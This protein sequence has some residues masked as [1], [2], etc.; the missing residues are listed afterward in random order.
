MKKIR[1]LLT[2]DH[3]AFIAG[4]QFELEKEPDLEV[5][6]RAATGAEA[7]RLVRELRPDLLLLDMELPD[8]SGVEVA[9]RLQEAETPVLILPL[10]G[11]SDPEYVTGVLE[12]GAAGYMTKD[13]S[14]TEIT[15]AVRKVAGGG[16]YVSSQVALD[17][18]TEQRHRL[19]AE[20]RLE[21]MQAEL[22]TLG[23]T[24]V[25]MQVLKLVA[26]GYNNQH[27]AEQLHRSEHTI[28][29][30]VDKLRDLLGVR[31]RPELVAWAW[32]HGIMDIDL[33]AYAEG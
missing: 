10:S 16:V 32:K 28:R 22:K 17:I 6:G 5:V 9:Q 7:L 14:L 2:D 4:I 21:Q 12:S 3:P 29:N 25:L 18:V 30:H 1:I 33:D 8:L 19:R 20:S 31:W 15:K 11:F 24:P 26:E 23:V 13:E 27:I